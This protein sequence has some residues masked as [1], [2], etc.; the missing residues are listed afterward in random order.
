MSGLE[1]LTNDRDGAPIGCRGGTLGGAGVSRPAR[2]LV[3][4][5]EI[6]QIQKASMKWA[7]ARGRDVSPLI[8]QIAEIRLRSPA[9]PI[10]MWGIH[11]GLLETAIAENTE[12]RRGSAVL[13]KVLRVG[14][15]RI[16]RRLPAQ[17]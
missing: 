6:A 3:E 13:H 14:S 4:I 7:S 8:A 5:A 1:H 17:R 12:N 2:G 11:G 9:H 10:N 16:A 15:F